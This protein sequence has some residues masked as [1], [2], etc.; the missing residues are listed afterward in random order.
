MTHSYLK[1]ATKTPASETEAARAV[2]AQMLADIEQNGEQAVR[3][4]ARKLDQWSSDI[5]VTAEEVERRT[6]AIPHR[7]SATSN[8]LRRR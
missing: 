6:K 4:Y 8:G 1:R 3:D 2:V 7:S 5:L